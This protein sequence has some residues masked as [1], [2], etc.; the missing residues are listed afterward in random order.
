MKK[1][2]LLV[3]IIT[4]LSKI[5]GFGR[6]VFLSYVYG[7]SATLTLISYHKQFPP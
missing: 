7:A 2:A 6:E 3:M 1:T 5:L 4:V